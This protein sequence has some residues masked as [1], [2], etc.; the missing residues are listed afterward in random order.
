MNYVVEVGLLK[1]VLII[2]DSLKSNSSIEKNNKSISS[3]A[4]LNNNKENLQYENKQEDIKSESS[5]SSKNIS[6]FKTKKDKKNFNIN[7]KSNNFKFL[8]SFLTIILLLPLVNVL[9]LTKL[10]K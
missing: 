2:E 6:Q 7:N 3:N 1:N 4:P 10:F 9:E 8:K 5:I